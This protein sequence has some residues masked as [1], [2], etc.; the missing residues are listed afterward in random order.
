[1]SWIPVIWHHT[2]GW[3][4]IR[5]SA[6][7]YSEWTRQKTT[8]FSGHYLRN[9]STLDIGFWVISVYFN[10]RN[11]LPKSGTFLLGHPVYTLYAL[12]YCPNR[13]E[14]THLKILYDNLISRTQ[15]Y[16]LDEV[17]KKCVNSNEKCSWKPFIAH[18]CSRKC[19]HYTNVSTYRLLIFT[20][21]TQLTFFTYSCTQLCTKVYIL[22]LKD[23]RIWDIAAS[24]MLHL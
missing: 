17:C 9:R 10:I 3:K 13:T 19:V 16:I 8:L 22:S 21:L 20:Y 6:D 18:S 2:Q 1:M 15:K 7:R 4:W 11:T 12:Y 23:Y 14:M 24:F 5:T